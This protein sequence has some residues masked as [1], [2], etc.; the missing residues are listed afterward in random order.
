M[1]RYDRFCSEM[2]AIRTGNVETTDEVILTVL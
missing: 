1:S 2:L